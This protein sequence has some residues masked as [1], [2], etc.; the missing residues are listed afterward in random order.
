MTGPIVTSDGDSVTIRKADG[1][2]VALVRPRRTIVGVLAI[3]ADGT[4]TIERDHLPIL[5]IPR[6]AIAK[7]ERFGGRSS[8]GRSAGRAFLYGAAGGGIVGLVV[9]NGCKSSGAFCLGEPATSAFAGVLI[10][11][12]AGAVIGALTPRQRWTEVPPSLVP[13]AR[14]LPE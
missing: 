4:L 14:T 3:R 1:E 9:G 13:L 2:Q 11:G 12:G 10:A 5:T 7:L 6:A 8:R